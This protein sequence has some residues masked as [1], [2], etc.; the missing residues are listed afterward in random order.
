[1]Q[2]MREDLQ[3]RE[4]AHTHEVL[5][6]KEILCKNCSSFSRQESITINEFHESTNGYFLTTFVKF[7][8]MHS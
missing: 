7:T 5:Q 8:D 3:A 6:R 2:A 1:M 4:I